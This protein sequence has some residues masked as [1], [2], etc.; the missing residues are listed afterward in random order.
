MFY[1]FYWYL[2]CA[3]VTV[4]GKP[5]EPFVPKLKGMQPPASGEGCKDDFKWE[6]FGRFLTDFPTVFGAWGAAL[7]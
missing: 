3:C 7:T 2:I 6:K 5:Q 4:H 1:Y